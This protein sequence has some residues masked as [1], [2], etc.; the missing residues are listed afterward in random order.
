MSNGRVQANKLDRHKITV[1]RWARDQRNEII[2]NAMK[3]KKKNEK[4][5]TKRGTKSK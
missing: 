3:G 2:T 1:N 4:K 5:K